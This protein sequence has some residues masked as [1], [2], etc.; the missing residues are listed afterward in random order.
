MSSDDAVMGTSSEGSSPILVVEDPA[1][2]FVLSSSFP[3]WEL[4]L[5]SSLMD[6]R[7]LL[8]TRRSFL[9]E[10]W[11]EP[12]PLDGAVFSVDA[13]VSSESSLSLS[14][15]PFHTLLDGAGAAAPL[16]LVGP[17]SSEELDLESSTLD[18]G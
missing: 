14:C 4:L 9:E 10:T 6:T 2:L 16:D 15:L 13:S 18:V 17:L 12:L 1:V 8:L 11:M 5:M 7:M 3:W